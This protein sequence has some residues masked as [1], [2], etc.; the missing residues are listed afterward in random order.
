MTV[1]YL[2]SFLLIVAFTAAADDKI[3]KL[4]EQLGAPSYKER[5][6][7]ENE[8]WQLLPDSEEALRE[9]VKSDDPEVKIRAGRVIEKYDKGILPGITEEVKL[10]IDSFWNTPK[11]ELYLKD[12]LYGSEFKDI[13]HIVTIMKLA[14]RKGIQLYVK[15]MLAQRDFLA[16][17]YLN[18]GNTPYYKFFIKKYAEQGDEDVYLNWVK[19]H[20]LAEKELAAY[21]KLPAEKQKE[22]KGLIQ[23]L[24][25]MTGNMDKALELA[26][27]DVAKELS[28]KIQALDYK[29]ILENEKLIQ[30]TRSIAEEKLSLLY[31]RLAGNKEQY[32]LAKQVFVDDYGTKIN[33]NFHLNAMHTLIAN[34]ELDEAALIADKLE[35]EWMVRI[36][37]LRGDLDKILAYGK[38]KSDSKSAAYVAFELAKNYRKEEAQKWLEKTKITELNNRWI[39][40]YAKAFVTVHGIDTAFDH[41]IDHI[42]QIDNNS[43]YQLYYALCPEYT[44]LASFV[45][46]YRNDEVR[47]N[48][49][50]LKKFIT[51]KLEGEERGTF[52]DKLNANG[53]T[54]SESKAKYTYEAAVYLNDE[55][56]I[57]TSYQDFLKFSKNILDHSKE[58]LVKEKYDDCRKVLKEI[59]PKDHELKLYFYLKMKISEKTGAKEEF[60]KFRQNLIES[61]TWELGIPDELIEFM[62]DMGDQKLAEE[63]LSQ[64]GY[65]STLNSNS[66][67]MT[68]I[69]DL[70]ISEGNLDLAEYFSVYFYLSRNRSTMYLFPVYSAE[71]YK[72]FVNVDFVRQLKAG[73][74]GDALKSA[75]HY[76]SISP[77]DYAFHVNI[78]NTLKKLGKKKESEAY[79][80]KYTSY[81]KKKLVAGSVNSTAM[82][83]W[84]WSAALCDFKLDEAEKLALKAVSL[85]KDNANIW[86]TLAEIYF[87]QGKI[88]K[89]VETQKKACDLISGERE[90]T[91]RA[92]L[93]RFKGTL[94][95]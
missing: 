82:N 23:S 59:N 49:V 68:R 10:K 19:V 81:Y 12:W 83:D 66:K 41:I 21:L 37:S 4:I 92:K 61:P 43:R 78:V 42:D 1:K 62:E 7:A 3:D 36:L 51:K 54:L 26:K 69:I 94:P 46:G 31:T 5:K 93:N 89:A 91:F 39:Y 47:D 2:I 44:T 15:Q 67:L 77:N 80:E 79:F 11:K 73:K 75:E 22:V 17:L 58:L 28:M 87:R 25:R 71:L 72:N 32:R 52:Y 8:L 29:G 53:T 14:E 6:K 9:A 33:K 40:Y 38:E 48:F 27:G 85:D 74:I 84:A 16:N 63:I 13:A 64:F 76:L 88:E 18:C 20:G 60:E 50:L 56:K 55:E 24:Y 65:H 45:V 90:I 86:D 70:A 35:P 30:S 95:K 34:G 57:K